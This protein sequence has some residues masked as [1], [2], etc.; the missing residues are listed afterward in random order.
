[1]PLLGM[2]LEFQSPMIALSLTH[3]S[4]TLISLSCSMEPHELD[5]F[6]YPMHAPSQSIVLSC[7][8]EAH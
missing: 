4:S 7:S 2:L 8:K 6:L 3:A 5:P 1:M